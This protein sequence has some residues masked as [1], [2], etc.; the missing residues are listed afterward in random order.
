MSEPVTLRAGDSVTWSRSE[1]DYTAAD[2]WA[3]AYRLIP[4]T[5]EAV[6]ITTIAA[7][8]TYTATLL[9]SD[10]GNFP[11]GRCTL[12]GVLTKSGGQQITL[13]IGAIDILPNLSAL[14][15]WDGRSTARQML[16]AVEATLANRASAGQLDV[17]EATFRDRGWKRSPETLLKLR[18][19][20][21]AE[22]RR[23]D[24]AEGKGSGGR[25]Y[26]RF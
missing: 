18:S 16:D 24:A 25:T 2:G 1:P 17:I 13:Y 10:T 26:V 9:A 7:G 22:V 5:G 6:A 12:V 14:S 8:D 3:L 15:A 4:P 20:L 11:A 21:L 23:E 19:Q